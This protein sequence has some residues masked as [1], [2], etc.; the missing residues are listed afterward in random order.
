MAVAAHRQIMVGPEERGIA[1]GFRGLR[2]RK[3]VGVAGALLRFYE[4]PKVHERQTMRAS[5]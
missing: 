4:Y 5:R 2:D 1:Q 3:L